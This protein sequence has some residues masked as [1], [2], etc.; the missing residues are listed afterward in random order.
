M[1]WT[2]GQIGYVPL[3]SNDPA[4]VWSTDNRIPSWAFFQPAPVNAI[5]AV[6]ARP[7][8]FSFSLFATN[9]LGTT[10]RAFTMYV[11]SSY[12]AW[13][14]ANGLGAGSELGDQDKDGMNNFAEIALVLDPVVRNNGYQPVTYDP[15]TKRLR[16]VFKRRNSQ[17][18]PDI[19][20]EVQVSNNLQT[21]TTIAQFGDTSLQENL[22]A[23]SI[24]GVA[25][26]SD[27]QYTVVDGVAQ[28][29]GTPRRWMRVKVSQ[30]Q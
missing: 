1:N 10:T 12:T 2:V 3:T 27:T 11:Q 20:Y 18:Y 16:A 25:V 15:A 26:G 23:Q 24:S 4:T 13:A 21:W 30:M 6:P 8:T 29:A 17:S 7:G 22:G 5:G 28:T 14:V 9:S 19:K